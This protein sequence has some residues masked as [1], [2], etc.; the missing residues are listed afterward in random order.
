MTTG[1][2]LGA[3]RMAEVFA[4]GGDVLK[5]YMAGIGP[6]PARHEAMVLASLTG[7]PLRVPVARGV[8][9]V[10]GRWGLRMSRVPGRPLAE[11]AEES[12][13][14]S[15]LVVRYAALHRQVNACAAAATLPDLKKRLDARIVRAPGLNADLARRL[16]ER[17]AR[18]PEGDR[19]C[20]GDFHPFNIMADGDALGIIDWPDATRGAPEA[21]VARSYVMVRHH[22]PALAEAYLDSVLGGEMIRA[23]VM[24]WVPIVA[25]ARL[26][27]N[28]PEETEALLD[29]CRRTR[30]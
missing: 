5:L 11:A 8:V 2:K 27:E 15:S 18:L 20:H 28:I 14:L 30:D 23:A 12:G 7:L 26:S 25:A 16:R 17:L 3:G 13:D 9:Q 1:Q 21:D 6:E 24:D 4:D 29:L 10:D 19:L 22:R